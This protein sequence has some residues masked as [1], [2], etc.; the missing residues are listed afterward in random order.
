MTL[1]DSI[2][3]AGMGMDA[4][5]QRIQVHAANMANLHTPNYVRQIP[6][7]NETAVMPFDQLLDKVRS[8]GPI[9]GLLAATPEGVQMGGT[10][11]DRTPGKKLYMPDHPEADA[12][13][14]VTMS[15]TNILADMS[16]ATVASR[17]YEANIAMMTI[18]RT[19]ANK[20]VELGRGR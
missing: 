14:Y 5:V 20:A 8:Q 9:D 16:D 13:G 15:N 3:I 4:Q 11:A 18:L 17:M 2:N 19:M 1:Q 12:D 10:V 7:L 6:V